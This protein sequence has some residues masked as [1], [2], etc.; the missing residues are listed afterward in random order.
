MRICQ[1]AD[2]IRYSR[3]TTA[4]LRETFLID[5]LFSSGAVQAVYV[6]LDRAVIGSAVPTE[7]LLELGTYD[8]L[9]SIHAGFGTS[10][11]AFCWGMGGENQDYSDMDP[12]AVASLR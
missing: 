6:D 4:E 11:Y 2:P 1:M 7:R 3:L 10:A 8:E 5:D 12:V 9:K